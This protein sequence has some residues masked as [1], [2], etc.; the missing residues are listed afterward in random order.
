M[1]KRGGQQVIPGEIE[2]VLM[3]NE[4][5]KQAVII[6]VPHQ[7]YGEQ[8][9]AF[10]VTEEDQDILSL[11]GYCQKRIA[12]YKVPDIIEKVAEIPLIQ[13]KADKVTL[14]KAFIQ[15]TEGGMLHAQK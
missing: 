15:N 5:V 12:A 9:V 13:G 8:I 10:V 2:R 4:H 1:I 14:R 7:V 3:N 6:G 11:Y